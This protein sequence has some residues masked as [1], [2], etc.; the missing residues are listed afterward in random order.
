MDDG[1]PLLAAA[2]TNNLKLINYLIDNGARLNLDEKNGLIYSIKTHDK[3]AYNLIKKRMEE[4]S[5]K[6]FT[7]Y[8]NEKFE[9]QSD[10]IKDMEIGV[11]QKHN[12]KDYN[13]MVEFV[14][15]ALPAIL[16]MDE[17]P[18]GLFT[19]GGGYV[20]IATKYAHKIEEY[21]KAYI[22]V[23]GST[24]DNIFTDIARNIDNKYVKYSHKRASELDEKFEEQSDP[25]KDMGIGIEEQIRRDL[26]A[27][28]IDKNAVIIEDGEIYSREKYPDKHYNEKLKE[29]QLKYLSDE[30]KKFVKCVEDKQPS[31]NYYKTISISYEKLENCVEEAFKNN[32]SPDDVIKLCNEFSSDHTKKRIKL[33]V[34][35]LTRTPEEKESDEENNIYVFIGY[36]DKSPVTING[37]KYYEDKFQAEKMIKIDKY[38]YGD[39]SQ[40]SAMK[41]RAQ[42]QYGRDGAVYMINIPKDFM[43]K[44]YY[45]EIP[46]EYRDI[47][48][49]YKKRIA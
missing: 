34:A 8:V 5:F 47:I 11:F 24:P 23:N 20:S 30:K 45:N 9:E 16:E 3:K 36:T 28:G 42:A 21:I 19:L 41:L 26:E 32:I 40:V 35:K 18:R 10:P 22:K 31:G 46:E 48:E 49:T 37:K 33:V 6:G 1:F 43:D 4:L 2:T 44:D 12:F 7:K 29:I 13:K 14:T 27:A 15:M 17:L 25:I 38:N 39:L